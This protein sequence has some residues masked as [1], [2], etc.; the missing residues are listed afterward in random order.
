MAIPIVVAIILWA[1]PWVFLALLG[2]ILVAA[3]D[4]LLAMARSPATPHWRWLTLAVLGAVLVAAWAWGITGCLVALV[5]A[6]MVL[7]TAQLLRPE[8]PDGSLGGLA[9]ACF[10][11][12]FFG[13]TG[14]CFGWLRL[15]PDEAIAG[16][17][18]LLYLGTIWG[19]DSGAYYAG[20]R[21]GRHKMAP[22]ISPNKTMEGLAGGIVA[23]FASAALLKLVLVVAVPWG[24]V[25]AIAAILAVTAPVGGLVESQ[26]KRAAGVKDSST[27]IPGHGGLL[28][29][30]D[31]LVY[32]AP[33]VLAYMVLA[34]L[35]P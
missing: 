2:S 29:R 35:A 3:G 13:L 6:T 32:S 23:S 20:S 16:R 8:A 28:D 11:V 4:E 7:P 30:T 10:V 19:G 14:A 22:R 18:L 27:L 5:G 17:L 24:H 33:P 21:L 9:V 26:L 34:G 25:L 31:S 1:P 15:W 12:L